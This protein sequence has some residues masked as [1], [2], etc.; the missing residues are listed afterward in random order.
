MQVKETCAHVLRYTHAGRAE[1]LCATINLLN[2]WMKGQWIDPELQECIYE[3]A[4]GRGGKTMAEICM[5]HGYNGQYQGMAR[6]QDMIGW[7]QLIMEGMICKEIQ[8]IQK[9]Y[10]SLSGLRISVERWTGELVTKLLEVT[11]GQW[12]YQNIPVHDKMPGT[13]AT[14]RKEDIQM[15]IEV[16]MDIGTEGLLDVDCHLGECNLGDLEDTSGVKATYWL[17]AIKAAQEAGRLEALQSQV[18]AAATTTLS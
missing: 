2:Q 14:L 17:L 1:A 9:T 11:H 3:Y 10:T 12:L 8:A 13:L 5:E 7:L 6:A 4:M 16:Q 15:E 18:N